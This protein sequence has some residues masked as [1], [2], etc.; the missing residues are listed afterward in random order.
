M[1]VGGDDDGA[2]LTLR[3]AFFITPSGRGRINPYLKQ[4]S[5]FILA[6]TS[7]AY[8]HFSSCYVDIAIWDFKYSIC[9]L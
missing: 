8:A 4:S 7:Y 5:S 1:A 3:N 6:G 2:A 9:L